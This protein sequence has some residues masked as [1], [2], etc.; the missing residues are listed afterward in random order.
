MSEILNNKFVKDFLA[1][2]GLYYTTKTSLKCLSSV[3]SAVKTYLLPL[4]WARDFV[5]EYGTWAVVT[6]CSKGIGLHYAHELGARGLNLVL[7]ARKADLLNKLAD[8]IK[9]KHNVQVEVIIVDFG[10]DRHIYKTI[11]KGLEGKDI[12]ILVNN[13]GVLY[14]LEYFSKMTEDQIWNLIQVN[15]SSMALM[16]RLVLPKMEE[17][18]KGAI[19][20]I[21]SVASITPLPLNNIYAASKAFVD[22]FTRALASEC[23]E[24]GITVQCVYPGPVMTDMYQAL[25]YE[26]KASL[27]SPSPQSYTRQAVRTLGFARCTNG[28]WTHSIMDWSLFFGSPTLTMM[29]HKE[30]IRSNVASLKNQ[31]NSF[32][33]V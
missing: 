17:K 14:G 8:D 15:I 5:D 20:N 12:G 13:V 10:E 30:F 27:W 1:L 25:D 4:I 2:A 28:Y 23:Q 24:K 7:I 22:F 11:E 32:K 29:I 18:K 31:I 33:A 16:T 3:Y 9:T 26:A 21:A 19:I 6:G